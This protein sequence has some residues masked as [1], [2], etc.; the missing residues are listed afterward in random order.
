MSIKNQTTPF[1]LLLGDVGIFIASLYLALFLRTLVLPSQESFIFHLGFF[2]I[3]FLAWVAVYFIVGLYER[4]I[5]IVRTT[6]GQKLLYAQ[7]INIAL[8]AFFFYFIRSETIAPKTIL[9]IYL[10]VST[11]LLLVWRMYFYRWAI[12][13][14]KARALL[15]AR[16]SE[17]DEL[18]AEVAKNG[19][20]GFSF[21]HTHTLAEPFPENLDIDVVVADFYDPEVTVLLPTLYPL[22][23][24]KVQFVDVHDV[25][26]SVFGRVALSML[27]HNW[28]V[29]NISRESHYLYEFTKRTVDI[30]AA[31]ILGAVSLIVYP[32]VWVAIK[33]DDG[34]GVFVVQERFGKDGTIIRIPKFRSMRTNDKGVWPTDNDSRV[35]RVGKTLRKTRIDELPQLFSILKGDLS[36][37]GPRPDIYDL[38]VSLSGDIPYYQLRNIVKPGLSG[39]AQIRQINPPHSLEETR[40]RLAYDFYY[41]KHRSLLLDLKIGLQ[42]IATLISR[43]GK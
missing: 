27:R 32:F 9:V 42:T 23:F 16:G 13:R 21:V 6:M 28:Y 2:W 22:L 12:P 19:H 35:T 26:E 14:T 34:G 1:V 30:V 41:I 10:I 7:C 40:M 20:Y 24:S 4:G 11:A 15:V 29:Q 37:I 43:T 39:W 36:L 17:V 5:V 8:A 33:L 25:Y 3:P 31:L 38:G 18:V